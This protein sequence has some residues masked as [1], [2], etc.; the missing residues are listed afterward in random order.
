MISPPKLGT[1]ELLFN[2]A[3]QLGLSPVWVAS[4]NTFAIMLG[5]QEQYI[6]MTRSPLN[7][8][9]SA[10]LAKNKYVTRR[11]LERHNLPNIPF[12]QPAGQVEAKAFL[13]RHGKIIAKP[14]SGAGAHDVH[15]IT[16][17]A[18]LGALNINEYILEKY[19]TGKELRYLLLDGKV[20]GVH[21]SDYGTS[22]AANRPLRRISYP[23]DS[24]D[25]DLLKLAL[26][27]ADILHLKFAAVDYLVDSS[28]KAYILEVNTMPGF[29][30]F[31]APSKGPVVDVA[32]LFL[33]SII[34]N[35]H[36]KESPILALA[37]SKSSRTYR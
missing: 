34:N 4:R 29:K 19:I 8:E 1:A 25:L 14:V 30:W 28:G 20:I 2:S 6:T 18:Q 35:T 5:K 33:E 15:I 16:T 11:I 7:S 3:R 13:K 17:S 31:H 36:I 37:N 21:R 26:R 22:V 9:T 12:I 32:R 27:I 23:S 24:W 10:A